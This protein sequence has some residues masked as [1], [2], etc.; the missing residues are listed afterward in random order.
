MSGLLSRSTHTA[1]SSDRDDRSRS[2]SFTYE[3]YEALL[4]K[5]RARG[6]EFT[7]Y[8]GGV[9]D[10]EILLRHDVDW[11]PRRAAKMARLEADHGVSATYFFLLSSPFYNPLYEET[12]EAID[13]ITSLGHDVGLHFSTHQYWSSEPADEEL[14]A[15]VDRERRILSSIVDEPIETV[16]F[17]IPPDWV[18]KRSYDGFTSTYEERFFDSIDYSADSNQRWRTSPPFGEGVPERLQILVH[19]GLWAET[20]Q[21]FAERLYRERD[22]RF[23]AISEFLTY[24]FIDDEVSRT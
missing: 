4:E 1:I 8:G 10:G 24:Q 19:P 21:A 13:R 20:D 6:H 18:L 15:A 3:T 22:D 23:G 9:D 16:S 11:S 2:I 17:H 5:L 14:E 7:S 12:R